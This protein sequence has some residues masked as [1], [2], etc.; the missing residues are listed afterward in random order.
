MRPQT[1]HSTDIEPVLP[2]LVRIPNHIPYRN[3]SQHHIGG[4][5]NDC[6]SRGVALIGETSETQSEESEFIGR[7]LVLR[8]GRSLA[9]YALDP[10]LTW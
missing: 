9:C 7:N 5:S 3:L 2:Y 8:I 6:L 4:T 1:T 10:K